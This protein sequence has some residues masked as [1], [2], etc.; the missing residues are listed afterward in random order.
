MGFIARWSVCGEGEADARPDARP[1]LFNSGWNR[2]KHLPRFG[3]V[4]VKRPVIALQT[5]I[6]R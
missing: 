5:R 1:G 6:T 3:R 2:G 4:T